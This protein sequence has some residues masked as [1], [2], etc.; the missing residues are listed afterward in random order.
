MKNVCRILVFSNVRLYKTY[1]RR[2]NSHFLHFDVAKKAKPFDLILL[3]I[4]ITFIRLL[5]KK[6]KRNAFMFP[7]F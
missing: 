2:R 6:E 4:Y 3:K 1:Q 7:A 5:E